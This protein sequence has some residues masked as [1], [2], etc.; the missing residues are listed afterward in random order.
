AEGI[1]EAYSELF[2][3]N[4]TA[5]KLDA[6]EIHNKLRTLYAGQ[7][8]DNTTSLI[9]KTFESLAGLADFSQ[10]AYIPDSVN[11]SELPF[12]EDVPTE[13]I[14]QSGT[15]ARERI[16]VKS[17]QYHINI[18]LPESRDQAVYDAIFR[19]L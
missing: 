15:V 13:Q 14:K 3:I 4:K 2:A 16:G 7:K 1:K 19:S 11:S 10:D 18:V 5:N 6:N 9:A 8:T 12:E 17:L